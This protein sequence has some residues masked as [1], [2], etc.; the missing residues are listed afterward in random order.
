MPKPLPH[1]TPDACPSPNPP[2]GG[3]NRGSTPAPRLVPGVKRKCKQKILRSPGQ[4]NQFQ[5][6]FFLTKIHFLQF[7]KWSKISF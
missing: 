5:R 6:K 7:Q 1:P 4:I 2:F 3:Y